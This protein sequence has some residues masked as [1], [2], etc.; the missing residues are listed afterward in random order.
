MFQLQ[1][2]IIIFT[3]LD[4]GKTQ[5]S[6][7]NA[8]KEHV[9]KIRLAARCRFVGVAQL[10]AAE[11]AVTPRISPLEIKHKAGREEGALE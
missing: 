10:E 9:D 11:Y 6:S 3:D 4:Y 1:Y 5:C 8:V 7:N 2:N